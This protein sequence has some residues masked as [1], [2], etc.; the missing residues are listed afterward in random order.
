MCF[1]VPELLFQPSMMGVEQAGLAETL[2]YVLS[3]FDLPSQNRLCQ[4][5]VVIIIIIILIMSIFLE[6]FSMWNVLICAEQV[7][8][9][10]YKTH[11]YKTLKTVGVQIIMLKHPT[12]QK[13]NPLSDVVVVPLPRPVQFESI[14]WIQGQLSVKT[15]T[16]QGSVFRVVVIVQ[17]LTNFWRKSLNSW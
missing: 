8:I 11:A 10:K 16:R 12:E 17:G 9:Q 15:G 7:Q 3:K 4:V 14:L 2:N 1:R 13:K 5:T 6:G